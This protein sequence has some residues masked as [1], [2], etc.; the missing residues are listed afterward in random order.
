MLSYLLLLFFVLNIYL[1]IYIYIYKC[2]H[3]FKVLV[4]SKTKIL[5]KD[6][7]P[8]L[9]ISCWVPANEVRIKLSS[10]I[11]INSLS[12]SL[13]SFKRL[14]CTIWFRC[15]VSYMCLIW[16]VTLEI[17]RITQKGPIYLGLNLY[18][19]HNW[20][21]FKVCTMFPNTTS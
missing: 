2:M 19:A 6:S 12:G 8:G 11:F 16:R 13:S 20:I 5:S 18:I 3:F 7:N 17:C 9:W 1:Y 15:R 14:T 10:G 21:F 4:Y